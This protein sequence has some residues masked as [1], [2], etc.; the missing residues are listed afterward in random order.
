MSLLNIDEK[1]TKTDLIEKFGM[2]LNYEGGKIGLEAYSKRY[3]LWK[4]YNSGFAMKM[5][6]HY[7]E[8]IC[9]NNR[10]TA[11]FT[12]AGQRDSIDPISFDIFDQMDLQS[13]I[14]K[15]NSVMIHAM[16]TL[17]TERNPHT[18]LNEFNGNFDE[19]YEVFTKMFYMK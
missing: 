3:S 2:R 7:Y 1:L 6:N 14:E 13:V 4:K 19:F 16:A 18:F 5:L 8:L 12:L 10:A 9:F 17:Y 11:H 15:C